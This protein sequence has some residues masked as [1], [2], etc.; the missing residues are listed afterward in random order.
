MSSILPSVFPADR[1]LFQFK[2]LDQWTQFLISDSL[3]PA[4]QRSTD[5]FAGFLANQTNLAIKGIVGIKAMSR[6]AL[7]DL[8]LIKSANYSVCIL[9][10]SCGSFQ[11]NTML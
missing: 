10:P 8:Q 2:L 6:I 3:I 5:D 9:S 11:L 7:R 4:E 1:S